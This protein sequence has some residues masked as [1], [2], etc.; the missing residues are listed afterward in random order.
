MTLLCV[1][2]RGRPIINNLELRR[3]LD[4]VTV[5]GLWDSVRDDLL[6]KPTYAYR[7]PLASS[8]SAAT[9]PNL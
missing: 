2:V 3:L 1:S 7:R 4:D 9:S 8:L 5:D 6:H